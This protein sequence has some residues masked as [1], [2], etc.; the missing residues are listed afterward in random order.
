MQDGVGVVL[1][2]QRGEI[3][4]GPRLLE[5]GLG[6]DEA[7]GRTATYGHFMAPLIDKA[8]TTPPAELAEWAYVELQRLRLFGLGN[9]E[10]GRLAATFI[11]ETARNAVNR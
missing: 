8:E 2:S 10:I 5:G 7:T 9:E 1:P 6:L 3:V 4:L 11:L